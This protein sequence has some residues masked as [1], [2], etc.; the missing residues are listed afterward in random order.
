[1]PMNRATEK[2]TTMA[3]RMIFVNI[4]MAITKT[5]TGI[6]GNSY[7]LV[8]DGLEST[9]D[10]ITS[11]VT[12]SGM[13]ISLRPPDH[14]H[15]YGHGKAESLAGVFGAL[16][17]L[18]TAGLIVRQSIREIIT[19]HHAPAWFTLPVLVAVVVVKELIFRRA[20]R[21]G[22]QAGSI[23]LQTDA[24]HQRSDALTSGAAFIGIAIALI[25]GKGFE[26]ADDWAALIACAVIV[27]NGIRLLRPALDE[28]MDTHVS[29]ETEATVRRICDGIDGVLYSEK[30]RIRKSGM[31]L[32]VDIHITVQGSMTVSQSHVIAHAVTD[33]L[34]ASAL[35]IRDVVVHIEPHD[36]GNTD[37]ELKGQSS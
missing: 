33:A 17:I 29:G 4:G 1:M 7:A 25:G 36:L 14:N 16:A 3:G 37:A 9:A 34:H 20:D 21:L 22:R 18:G 19:P 30:C 6:I 8:A 27:F 10:V 15:P 5:V 26:T 28:V 32:L 13:R 23:A 11:C 31:G 24:W 2:A 35:S 12:W